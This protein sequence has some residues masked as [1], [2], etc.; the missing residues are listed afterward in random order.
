MLEVPDVVATSSCVGV[1]VITCPAADFRQMRLKQNATNHIA[2][3]ANPGANTLPPTAASVAKI[4][5]AIPCATRNPVNPARDSDRC[6]KTST[7]T[8]ALGAV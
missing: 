1:I 2:R 3:I 7:D 5:I 4:P 6:G 8:T